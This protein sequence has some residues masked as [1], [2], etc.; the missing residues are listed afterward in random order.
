VT[1]VL[2]GFLTSPTVQ[3]AL[4]VGGFVA[5]VTGVVGV[6]TVVRAQ[7]FAGH[8]LADL[9]AVGGSGAFLVGVSQLWGFVVA[10]IVAALVIE[11]IGLRRLRG[12]D[13][14]TGIVFAA[15]LGLAALFL[16]WDTTIGGSSNAA[17]SVLFGSLFVIDPSIVP[18]VVALS[19][20]SVLLVV[21]VWRWLL[22]TAVHPDLAA[23]RG[24]PVRT[25][26]MLFA[27]ALAIAV[28]LSS[29]S[30]GAILSTALLVG[31]PATALLLSDR[32]GRTVLL[33][34]AIGVAET[35]AGC[36]L[37]YGSASWTGAG[38]NWP[39]SAC[40]VALVLVVYL[41]ARVRTAVRPRRAEVTA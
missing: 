14:T 20:V 18:V 27:V 39:V 15:G 3:T 41:G 7:S 13:V 19:L 17:I 12:R 6:F 33:A 35:W 29:L 26:G 10:S 34:A 40:I 5:A 8:A 4:V 16:Y 22:L 21:A 37:S 31:P 9:G 38:G 25:V 11:A 28:A 1:A 2:V 23:T 30:I 36:L 32:F 24:V